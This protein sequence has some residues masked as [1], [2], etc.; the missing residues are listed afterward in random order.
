M[1]NKAILIVESVSLVILSWNS[2]PSLRTWRWWKNFRE[3]DCLLD[4]INKVQFQHIPKDINQVADHLANAGANLMVVTATVIVFRSSSQVDQWSS[5]QHQNPR[6]PEVSSGKFGK[7]VKR[8]SI[9]LSCEPT[10]TMKLHN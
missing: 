7:V 8:S 4:R 6:L 3:L 2:D 10:T 1:V 5:C 9:V